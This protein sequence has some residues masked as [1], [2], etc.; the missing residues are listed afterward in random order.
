MMIELGGNSSRVATE[1]TKQA[2]IVM[3]GPAMIRQMLLSLCEKVAL[4]TL[5]VPTRF[6]NIPSMGE[7][8]RS[9]RKCNFTIVTTKAK[10]Q[11]YVVYVHFQRVRS[12]QL[13]G[14]V[15]TLCDG[16]KSI[17]D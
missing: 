3:F 5:V 15:R 1:G 12:K 13:F 2:R 4:I 8:F 9:L 16:F 11:V 6:V 14:A 10:L 7:K 17:S